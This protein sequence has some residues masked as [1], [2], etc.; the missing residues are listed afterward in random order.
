M[1]ACR[2]SGGY[3]GFTCL[4][5]RPCE[6]PCD[7]RTRCGVAALGTTAGALLIIPPSTP[8]IAPPGTPP[9][10]PDAGGG[11]SSSLIMATFFGMAVGVRNWPL[12]KSLVRGFTIC[13]SGIA[14][15]GGGGG[16]GGGATRKVINCCFGSASVNISGSNTSTPM[17][18]IWRTKEI[19]VVAPCLFFNLPPD[20]TRLSSN[21][22]LS[23]SNSLITL[24]P[25]YC[26][27]LPKTRASS[28]AL[29]NSTHLASATEPFRQSEGLEY[30]PRKALCVHQKIDYAFALAFSRAAVAAGK[31]ARPVFLPRHS[32]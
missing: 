12:S 24:T 3:V 7:T 19:A 6:T 26:F 29:P 10:T 8:P 22:A 17:S 18:R 30:T 23:P 15:G 16:G 11:G 32:W 28:R 27:L 4:T 2:A 1:R 25:A 31:L 9:A 5:N 14:A 20:S 13:T 21:I